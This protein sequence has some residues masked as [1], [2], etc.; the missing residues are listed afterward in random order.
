MYINRKTSQKSSQESSRKTGEGLN[1][2]QFLQGMLGVAGTAAG[3]SLL[4]SEVFANEREKIEVEG[5]V[6]SVIFINMAG[7]MSHV[8]TFDPK[9]NG[10]FNAINSGIRGAKV[11][12]RLSKTAKELKR[13]NLIRSVHSSEGSHERGSYLLHSGHKAMSGFQDIPSMGAVIA[14]SR[15]KKGPYFPDHVTLGGKRG[16]VGEGGFLGKRFGSFHVSNL[17]K[18]LRNVQPPWRMPEERLFRREMML[19]VLNKSFSSRVAGKQVRVYEDMHKASLEF[20][21]S[22]RLRVFDLEKESSRTKGRF[23]DSNF[24]KACLM[25][26]RLARAEVPFIEVTMGGWDTHNNHRE[27][28]EKNLAQVDPAVAALLGELGSSGLLKQTLF[29]LSSEFGR[30]PDV[31]SNGDGRDHHPRAWTTVIGG[32]D[33]PAG[34]VIGATDKKGHRPAKDPV[35]LSSQVATIYQAAGIDPETNLYSAM[36]RPMQLVIDGEIIQDFFD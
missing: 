8:D 30:T 4:S 29:V 27:R 23:G 11:S 31:S 21:N 18:P 14:Y 26:L 12:D 7:G 1:R 16:L 32:G 28:M 17:K 25:A 6:K 35:H 10:T 2:K 33:L 13:V 22:D 24:G 36:G 5:P 3:A 34:M 19:E 20:M 9:P 15:Y